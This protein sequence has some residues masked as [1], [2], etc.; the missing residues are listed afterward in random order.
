[1]ADIYKYPDACLA[2]VHCPSGTTVEERKIKSALV[3]PE[4]KALLLVALGLHVNVVVTPVEPKSPL[5]SDILLVQRL[6]F[7]CYCRFDNVAREEDHSLLAKEFERGVNKDADGNVDINEALWLTIVGQGKSK[8]AQGQPVLTIKIYVHHHLAYFALIRELRRPN[9]TGLKCRNGH[10]YHV[11]LAEGDLAEQAL[12]KKEKAAYDSVVLEQAW[13]EQALG[14]QGMGPN[15][16]LAAAPLYESM[17]SSLLWQVVWT[18]ATIA[19]PLQE[20]VAKRLEWLQPLVLRGQFIQQHAMDMSWV[21]KQKEKGTLPFV[22]IVKSVDALENN[23]DFEMAQLPPKVLA[24]R[25]ECTN[26]RC[27]GWCLSHQGQF[28]Q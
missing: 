8:N 28:H 11:R 14:Q 1:M 5:I 13:C 19:N 2:L 27:T 23:M 15:H 25:G 26:W 20:G 18:P 4:Q 24:P 22:P 12:S 3:W 17:N 9:P 6:R 21:Q 7:S 10:A 16:V